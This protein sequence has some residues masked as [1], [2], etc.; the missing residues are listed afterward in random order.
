M[1]QIGA[2]LRD[3]SGVSMVLALGIMMVVSIVCVSTLKVASSAPRAAYTQQDLEQSYLAATSAAKLV[4]QA[5]LDEQKAIEFLRA[6]ETSNSTPLTKTFTLTLSNNNVNSATLNT[7]N[8]SI[9]TAS[10]TLKKVNNQVTFTINGGGGVNYPVTIPPLPVYTVT[11]TD[12]LNVKHQ[13]MY[14]LDYQPGGINFKPANYEQEDG[15]SYTYIPVGGSENTYQ[16]QRMWKVVWI[17][18]SGSA[19]ASADY[20]TQPSTGNPP[21]GETVTAFG[22]FARWDWDAGHVIIDSTQ[23]V[24]V[25]PPVFQSPSNSDYCEYRATW[26]T[27]PAITVGSGGAFSITSTPTHEIYARQAYT[28]QWMNGTGIVWQSGANA[29]TGGEVLQFE[30]VTPGEKEPSFSGTTPTHMDESHYYTFAGWNE[31]TIEG[32]IKTYSPQFTEGA[33]TCTVIWENGDGSTLDT[34]YYAAGGTPP[35]TSAVPTK[36]ADGGWNYDFN[37]TWDSGTTVGNVTTYKPRFT[38]TV[39][40]MDGNGNEAKTQTFIAYPT[41]ESEEPPDDPTKAADENEWAYTFKDWGSVTY[42]GGIKIY[43]PRFTHTV[44]WMN[45]DGN[46]LYSADFLAGTAEPTLPKDKTPTK[47]TDSTYSYEFANWGDPTIAGHVK[48]YIPEFTETLVTPEN[49]ENILP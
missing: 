30:A 15:F 4:K 45:G 14:P 13:E 25:V 24:I 47:A 49:P 19:V 31:G 21:N 37:H 20:E 38:H 34:Q 17:D 16:S 27:T 32:G 41:V 48:T 2:K 26:T 35:S 28:V 40:W 33:E 36:A 44:R 18:G 11:W 39:K 23:R 46:E 42:S 1:K 9:L 8:N 12:D 22:G 3:A 7:L 5:F 43:T 10:V 6:L 29:S